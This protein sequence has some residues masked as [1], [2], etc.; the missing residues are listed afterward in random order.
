MSSVIDLKPNLLLQLIKKYTKF[1]DSTIKKMLEFEK[2][3]DSNW[4]AN[5]KTNE[6]LIPNYNSLEYLFAA[7]NCYKNFSRN[8]S[9]LTIKHLKDKNINSILDVGAGIGATTLMFKL[10]F[11]NSIVYYNNLKGFQWNF[12][13]WLFKKFNVEINMV[14]PENLFS[15]ENVD[16]ILCFEFFEHIKQPIILL[17]KLIN[18]NPK[19]F[20]ITN[21]WKVNS[22][23]HFLKYI[24]DGELIDRKK[25][26]K[27][28]NKRIEEKY[29]LMDCTNTFWNSRPRLYERKY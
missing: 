26:A 16:L 6:G 14:S 2:E 27:I 17:E 5:L 10:N 21:S 4:F 3:L 24:V 13:E 25:M 29:K 1:D 23:G 7:F 28:F 11:K 20:A 19:Y 8:Y 18:M 9:I 22:Y 12:A 15:I